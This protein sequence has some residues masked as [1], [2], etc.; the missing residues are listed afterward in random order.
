MPTSAVLDV[1]IGLVFVYWLFSVFCS[2][3]NEWIANLLALRARTLEAAIANLLEDPGELS[4]RITW[5]RQL[6]DVFEAVRGRWPRLG[7]QPGPVPPGAQ[8]DRVDPNAADIYA[9]GLVAALSRKS[10]AHLL[11]GGKPA[12]MANAVS[13]GL[14]LGW[15]GQPWPP[16]G[17]DLFKG[18]MGLFLTTLA[19]SL[20][21]PFWFDVLKSLGS[22]KASGPRPKKAED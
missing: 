15:G 16:S 2:V 19:L 17:L 6:A 9:H 8:A 11:G 10:H 1:A 5:L 12:Y 22:L 3:L 21:A 7:P 13:L 4:T 14:P 18:V 20:G